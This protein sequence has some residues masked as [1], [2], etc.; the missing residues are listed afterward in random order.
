MSSVSISEFIPAGFN[1]ATQ[2]CTPYIECALNTHKAVHFPAGTYACN[3]V[4]NSAFT[5][6][7]DGMSQTILKPFDPAKPVIKNMWI[8]VQ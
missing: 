4:L 5:W 7:G 8:N 3:I 6:S 1:T 2:D